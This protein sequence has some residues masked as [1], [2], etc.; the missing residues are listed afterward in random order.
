MR[1]R[2]KTFEEISRLSSVEKKGREL[3]DTDTLIYF[4]EEMRKLLCSKIIEVKKSDYDGNQIY[5]ATSTQAPWWLLPNWVTTY[6]IKL[7][8]RRMY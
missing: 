3:C 8:T 1:V 5:K 2:V 6:N 4:T 7:N